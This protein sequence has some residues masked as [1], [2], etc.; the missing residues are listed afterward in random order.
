MPSLRCGSEI[1]CSIVVR[2]AIYELLSTLVWRARILTPSGLA[3]F[4]DRQGAPL[5]LTKHLKQVAPIDEIGRAVRVPKWIIALDAPV[6][7]ATL[8]REHEDTEALL[9]Q[10][11]VRGEDHRLE[12]GRRQLVSSRGP[13]RWVEARPAASMRCPVEHDLEAASKPRYRLHLGSSD[14]FEHSQANGHADI[15]TSISSMNGQAKATSVLR[16]RRACLALR[17][18][19]SR[20]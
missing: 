6:D 19:T 2:R 20:A 8:P 3:G 11:E 10:V 7:V 16:H 17:Q 1:Y 13:S 5:Y 14:G 12:K 9:A 4:L 18:L 15:A